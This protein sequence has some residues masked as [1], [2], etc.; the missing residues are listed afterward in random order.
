MDRTQL[1]S[2]ALA[3]VIAGSLLA[4]GCERRHAPYSVRET[5]DRAAEVIAGDVDG[6]RQAAEWVISNAGAAAEAAGD[7]ALTAK[8][9]SALLSEL[10]LAALRIRVDTKDAIVTLSGPVESPLVR[11]RAVHTA[12]RV[13]GVRYVLHSIDLR[14]DDQG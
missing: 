8:V 12:L 10:A 4:G 2:L 1:K 14:S 7:V 3:L 9:K 6:A 11:E 5:T 13:V